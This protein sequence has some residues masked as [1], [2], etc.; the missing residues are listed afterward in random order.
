MQ[1]SKSFLEHDNMMKK[2]L[3]SSTSDIRQTELLRAPG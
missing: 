3:P 1:A 2:E